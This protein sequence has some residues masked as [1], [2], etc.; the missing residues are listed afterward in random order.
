MLDI[1]TIGTLIARHRNDLWL[2]QTDLAARARIGRSTLDALE[3]GRI[4]ELGFG[5]I[6]RVLAALGLTLKITDSNNGRP[7]LDDL[8]EDA[9]D[10]A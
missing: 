2:T 5:K 9:D 4:A 7:T 8:R 3:N 1:T 10:L 6:N